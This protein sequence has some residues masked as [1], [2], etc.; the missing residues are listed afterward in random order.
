MAV[1][2]VVYKLLLIGIGFWAQ[3]RTRDETDFFL[4][5]R[6]LGPLVAAIS[7][8]SSASSAWT[9]LGLS[10][11][12]FMLGI[13]TL[14]IVLGSIIGMLVAW[15]WIGP[16]L[17]RHSREPGQITLTDFL[18]EGSRDGAKNAITLVASLSILFCFTFYGWR[19]RKSHAGAR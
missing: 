10:G 17:M 9:L 11:L 18:A 3:S 4:G 12:A 14:W 8:S 19:R 7:Y 5:G 1:T 15:Y 2:L 16:R 13:S 6:G